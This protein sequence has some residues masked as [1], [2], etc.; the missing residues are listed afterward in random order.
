M[1]GHRLKAVGSI[2]WAGAETGRRRR[3]RLSRECD[4]LRRQKDGARGPSPSAKAHIDPK[5]TFR[6]DAMNGRKARESGL[7]RVCA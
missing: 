6:F 3:T 2:Y 7:W 4:S 1:R 5:A